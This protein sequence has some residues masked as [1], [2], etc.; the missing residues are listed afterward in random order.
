MILLLL[1]HVYCNL[2]RG[3]VYSK[4]HNKEK[5]RKSSKWELG[6][7]FN[8]QK[9]TVSLLLYELEY[10]LEKLKK[11]IDKAAEDQNEI[12]TSGW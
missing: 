9:T 7:F 5:C 10:K 6:G 2:F 1:F 3:F 4:C 12:R 8:L 11:V